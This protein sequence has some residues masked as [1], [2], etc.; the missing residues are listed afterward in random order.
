MASIQQS[1]NQLVS[2]SL[3]AAYGFSHARPVEE[4]LA[5]R[6]ERT[7]AM[8]VYNQAKKRAETAAES[9]DSYNN[10]PEIVKLVQGERYKANLAE[11][12][13][14]A[15]AAEEDRMA[16]QIELAEVYER[17]GRRLPGLEEENPS[18]TVQMMTESAI[19]LRNRRQQN[20]AER[21]RIA[22]QQKDDV[23]NA[24]ARRR[25]ILQGLPA[26]R[27]EELMNG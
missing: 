15:I 23:E 5:N 17:Q 22:Q 11:K 4:A 20:A 7:E 21:Q 27:Q 9:Y 19:H 14:I 26:E 8:R 6:T 18:A 2:A 12:E 25:A 13:E 24:V 10:R 1:L 16:K 3:G